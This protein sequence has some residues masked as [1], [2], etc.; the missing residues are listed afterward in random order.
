MRG[1]LETEQN[2]NILTPTLMAIT[3]F[4]SRSPGLHNRGPAGPAFLGH[5][6]HP[7]FS[8]CNCSIGGLRVP[9]AGCLFSLPHLISNSDSLSLPCYIIVRRQLFFPWASQFH[10]QFN[11]STVKV[12]SWYPSTGL[13]CYLQRCISYFDSLAGSEVNLEQFQIHPSRRTVVVQ[14]IPYLGR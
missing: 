10:T 9:S 4:L 2:C 5:G 13:T 3:A 14:F 7:S 1:E 11:L 8:N 6:S 12:I